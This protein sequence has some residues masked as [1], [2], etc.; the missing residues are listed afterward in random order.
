MIKKILKAIYIIEDLDK[1]Q[2]LQK[3]QFYKAVFDNLV[4]RFVDWLFPK[5]R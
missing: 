5:K 4:K 1:K 3:I 2:P